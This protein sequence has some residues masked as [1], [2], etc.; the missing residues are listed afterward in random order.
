MHKNTFSCINI[1]TVDVKSL[2]FPKTFLN[3]KKAYRMTMPCDVRM[4]HDSQFAGF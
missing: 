1:H 3:P 4:S 2:A